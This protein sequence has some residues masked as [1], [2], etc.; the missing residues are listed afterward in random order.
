MES[1]QRQVDGKCLHGLQKM[2]YPTRC[3]KMQVLNPWEKKTCKN[4]SCFWK[5]AVCVLQG[6]SPHKPTAGH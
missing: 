3:W 4:I 6:Q 5:T 1:I 2:N